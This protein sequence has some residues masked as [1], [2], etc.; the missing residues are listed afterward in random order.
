MRFLI[1]S[2]TFVSTYSLHDHISQRQVYE[3]KDPCS[4]D[5]LDLLNR[6]NKRKMADGTTAGTQFIS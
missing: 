6:S 4:W 1:G 2:Q 5:C 3:I